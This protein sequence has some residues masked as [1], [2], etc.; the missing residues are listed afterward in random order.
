M[1]TIQGWFDDADVNLMGIVG[2]GGIGKSAL[3]AYFYNRFSP[4]P[5]LP[6]PPT[7]PT[8]KFWADVSLNPDFAA[9]AESIIKGLSGTLNAT[10]DV[11]ILIADL[12]KILH[13]HRC[14][15]VVDNV[16]TLLNESGEWQSENYTT[17]FQRWKQQGHTSILLL[18]T[19]DKPNLY[20]GNNY[21]YSLGTFTVDE[22][23]TLLKALQIEGSDK[24]LE[25]LV[26][27]INGHALTLRLVAAYLK[28]YCDSQLSQ[29]RELG[30][31][32]FELI[33][34][35]ASG[36]HRHKN[37]ARLSWILEQHLTRLSEQ[38][39]QFLVNLSVYRQPFDVTA[40]T[41]M[42]INANFTE[43]ETEATIKPIEVKK[44]LQNLANRSLLSRSDEKGYECPLL[45][46][47]Y[48]QKKYPDLTQ[49]HQI[50]INYYL[51]I[52]PPKPWTNLDQIQGYLEI[53]YH[54]YQLG[55]Y[56]TAFDYLRHVDEFM[57]LQ[58]YY[59]LQV[60]YYSDLVRIYEE[61]EDQNN[62]NYA[63]S[64]TSLG[65]AYQSLGQYQ[66][67][68]QHHQQ[69]LAIFIEIENRNGEESSYGNLGNAYFSL[70]KYQEAIEYYQQSLAITTEIGDRNGEANSY[71]G[72]G[73]AYFSLGQY[74]QAIEDYNKSLAIFQKIGD[75]KGEANSYSNLGSAYDSLGKYQE[76]IEYHQQSLAITTEIGDRNGEATSY[77]GLGIAYRSLG[78]YQ[79]AIEYYQQSLAIQTEIG[80]RNGEANSYGNLGNAY[81]S[82]GQYQEAI[83]Y[84]QQSLAITTE[85]GDRN[86]EANS[87]IGL[88]N[89]YSSLGQYQQAIEYHQQSLAIQTEIGD[90]NGEANSYIG[91]GNTYSSLGQYQQAIEYYQQSLAITTEIG[92]HNG[93][94]S[95]YNNFGNVYYLLGQYQQ[96]IQYYQQSLA[97][98]T[99]I[100]AHN[101]E[102]TSYMGLGNAYRS[103]GQYQ[104]A[105]EYYQQSLAIKREIGDRYGEANAWF[106]LG[107]TL[108]KLNRK[109]EAKEC[110]QKSRQLYQ[111]MGLDRDVQDCNNQLIKLQRGWLEKIFYFILGVIKFPVALV[112]FV[113]LKVWEWIRKMIH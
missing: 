104:Q 62:W 71:I 21:W 92:A 69:S 20:R 44:E 87:Y 79:E 53:F 34:E 99:E 48:L 80:D 38:Q 30:L 7:L 42:Y 76:A 15:L 52:V 66:Q 94:A 85:I 73:N 22:G 33:Y 59:H 10:G 97:I 93:E 100:G 18:T 2:L 32:E 39:R 14:L 56:D 37:D 40:A 25:Q 47:P 16:E 83:E 77:I 78:K 23:K 4:S 75:R 63:A 1:T 84:H 29:V 54:W 112:V 55:E 109:S 106:N 101:G 27:K 9:F 105:I 13:Q 50:A 72:L 113:L 64:L 41:G 89:A 57:T 102:A 19:R 81:S 35:E 74:Q 31:D 61:I 45:L 67:A 88:G 46:K 96:A 51:S 8:L 17:F 12:F 60:K 26:T 49:C 58:G 110:Y 65:N 82:L 68:I 3:A 86:G 108:K 95:S 98:T 107:L 28:E 24:D 36:L 111:V 103:L 91:L 90:R 70:G 43:G 6:T 5:T 11:N